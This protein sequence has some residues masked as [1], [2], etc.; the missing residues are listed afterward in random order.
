[1]QVGENYCVECG[2]KQQPLRRTLRDIG[3]EFWD[4]TLGI[5]S[6]LIRS[7]RDLLFRPGFLTAAYLQGK[8]VE[9]L[10]PAS[11]FL[12]TAGVLFL[13]LEWMAAANIERELNFSGK[14]VV[15]LS[16][17]PGFNITVPSEDLE[18]VRQASDEELAS[19][20]GT[21]AGEIEQ[22][23]PAV[24]KIVTEALRTVRDDGFSALRQ[25]IAGVAS[26]LVPVL[27]PLM[28]ILVKILHLRK[29]LYFAEAIVFCL[30]V[31]AVAFLGGAV[32]IAIPSAEWQATFSPIAVVLS[33]L[34]M[35]ISLHASLGNSVV[36]SF[37]KA[38]TV[39]VLHSLVSLFLTFW[40]II[41]LLYFA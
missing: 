33:I 23:P 3:A 24:E 30:H 37:F 35:T 41:G 25:Q 13:T 20:V 15:S 16:V 38:L 28:A 14:K 29:G 11:L 34:Y 18:K 9:Y 17:L 27:V 1:M 32:F 2:Q 31:H 39:L 21:I 22:L 19:I 6:K 36:V 10:R 4:S 7:F 40:L 8:R 12:L 26:K 5:D